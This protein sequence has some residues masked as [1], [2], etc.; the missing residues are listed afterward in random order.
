[1]F[2][3]SSIKCMWPQR[4]KCPPVGGWV[5]T[6]WYNHIM[7]YYTAKEMNKLLHAVWMN[8]TSMKL[9]DSIIKLYIIKE[10]LISWLKVRIMVPLFWR[11]RTDY[12]G[13]VGGCW[14]ADSDLFFD[15]DNS[16]LGVFTLWNFIQ[17]RMYHLTLFCMYIS[18]FK[19]IKTKNRGN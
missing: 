13:A 5:Y 1:M 11:G 18:I 14:D 7:K 19:C 10:K 8:L 12:E 15:Q 4:S 3:Y 9:S 17:L 6:L 2:I 16:C